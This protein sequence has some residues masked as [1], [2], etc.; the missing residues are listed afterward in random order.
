MSAD[1]AAEC[2][3]LRKSI[4]TPGPWNHVTGTRTYKTGTRWTVPGSFHV[5]IIH[6]T[7]QGNVISYLYIIP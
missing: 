1:S 5:R 4:I 6:F 7:T 3:L 2:E